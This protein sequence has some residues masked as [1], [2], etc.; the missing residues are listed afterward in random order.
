[1]DLLNEEVIN[2]EM[3]HEFRGLKRSAVANRRKTTNAEDLKERITG[4]AWMNT[5]L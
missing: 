2:A 4:M 5:Q 3:A 1:M